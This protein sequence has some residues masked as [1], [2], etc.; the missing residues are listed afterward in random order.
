MGRS[1]ASL[2][3]VLSLALFGGEDAQARTFTVIVSSN[4]W[5]TD[6]TIARS[7]I[8]DDLIPERAD[9]PAAT[10]LQFGWGDA[11]YYTE[12][13]PGM[14]TTLGAAFPGPAVMHVAGLSRR[15]SETFAGVEEVAVTLDRET[16]ERL[17]AYL[18]DS[19]ARGGEARVA[20]TAPGVYSF[21]RF[22]PATGEFHLFNTCNTWTAR[23][24]AAAGLNISVSG[25]KEAGDVMGQ[26]RK[27]KAESG[28]PQPVPDGAG[29]VCGP[30]C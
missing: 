2:W 26:L 15:P 24:L 17:I 22:Y 6:I 20:S 30:Q 1:L 16:F 4:G 27:D 18:H 5:H 14:F 13:K 12:P 9:F 10:F 7:D 28:V 25:V 19:F 3:L 11:D 21:S 8:P 23:G 29:F